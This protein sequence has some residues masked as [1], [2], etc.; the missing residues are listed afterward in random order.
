M[1]RTKQ[2]IFGSDNFQISVGNVYYTVKDV[3]EGIGGY[4]E[5]FD[6]QVNEYFPEKIEYSKL[7][8]YRGEFKSSKILSSLVKVD[9][10][11]ENAFIIVNHVVST[12]LE[13]AEAGKYADGLSTHKIRKI[14]ANTILNYPIEKESSGMIEEWADKYV[15][16]YGHNN[17]RIRIYSD[18]ITK[19]SEVTFE[20]IKDVL[21]ED[22]FSDLEIRKKTYENKVS[23]NQIRSIS[24][25]IIEFINNCD[26]YKINYDIL[27]D[28]I[29]EMSLQPPHPWFVTSR[30]AKRISKYDL[31]ILEKHYDKLCVAKTNNIY[32]DLYATIYEALHHSTSSIL[33]RYYEVLGCKDLDAFYNLE[34]IVTK[35]SKREEEDLLVES[36]AVNDLPVDLK[37]VGVELNQFLELLRK[38]KKKLTV[39]RNVFTVQEE[40]VSNII[41]LCDIAKSLANNVN[42][43]DIEEFL[44]SEWDTFTSDTIRNSIKRIFEVISG[45][46]VSNFIQK[47]PDCFWIKRDNAKTEKEIFTICLAENIDMQQV[48][49]YI[50]SNRMIL[51]TEAI[52]IIGEYLDRDSCQNIL[53]ELENENYY[54]EIICKEDLQ[55]IFGSEKKLYEFNELL[56]REL[57]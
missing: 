15:R 33:A 9:I 30:T 48:V 50:T 14:V 4:F 47:L 36:Y 22:V 45:L 23:A 16:R 29:T 44:Y 56:R 39:G 26:M 18:N 10:P 49:S 43:E 3:Y 57:N 54:I 20:F 37:Y 51:N 17:Q 27:K 34:Q 21:L 55:K 40:F 5:N 31:E 35:L 13:E 7:K 52:L 28:F 2:S 53:K 32:D 42:K 8:D 46:K 12:I 41:K 24:R 19:N 1:K 6:K 11:F 38:I 25:E